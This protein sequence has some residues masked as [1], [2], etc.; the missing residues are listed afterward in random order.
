MRNS[1]TLFC[2]LVVSHISSAQL[3][4]RIKVGSAVSET[5]AF[6]VEN[7][8]IKSGQYQTFTDETGTAWYSNVSENVLYDTLAVFHPDY[9]FPKFRLID[10]P[11]A[12]HNTTFYFYIEGTETPTFHMQQ[13][14]VRAAKSTKKAKTLVSMRCRAKIFNDSL[15]LLNN[16]NEYLAS[17]QGNGMYG[18]HIATNIPLNEI[19]NGGKIVS[20]I[21]GDTTVFGPN[22]WMH[23]IPLMTF[24]PVQRSN[25][26]ISVVLE[27]INKL[28]EKDRE[29]YREKYELKRTIEHLEDSI[30]EILHPLTFQPSPIEMPIPIVEEILFE[31][32]EELAQHSLSPQEFEAKITNLIAAENLKKSG[33]LIFEITIQK[34]GRAH[35]RSLASSEELSALE[36]A[37]EIF[38]GRTQWTPYK[39]GG[40]PYRSGQILQINIVS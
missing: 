26:E 1:I 7:A 23:V 11:Y 38:L 2:L 22:E 30:S 35:V 13:I 8:F 6:P 24:E 32:T 29:H 4:I 28:S 20:G 14:D 9:T 10:F 40:K 18:N 39:I 25:S 21:R 37:I 12:L 36:M 17:F 16:N 3:D 19:E 5:D 33:E 31:L 34:D 15:S 27:L